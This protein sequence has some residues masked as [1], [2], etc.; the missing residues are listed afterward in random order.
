MPLTVDEVDAAATKLQSAHKG[1]STRTGGALLEAAIKKDD[2]GAVTKLLKDGSKP[3]PQ[4]LKL[5]LTG[6]DDRAIAASIVPLSSSWGVDAKKL[7]IWEAVQ[8]AL[9]PPAGGEDDEAAEAADV[10]SEEWQVALAQKLYGEEAKAGSPG[11]YEVKKV[12]A[13]GVYEGERAAPPDDPTY[14]PSFDDEKTQR[15]GYGVL[16]LPKGDV[17]VGHFDG[18]K[19]AGVGAYVHKSGGGVYVGEWKADKKHGEGRMAFKD[20]AV[21]DGSWRHHKRHG[22]GVYRYVNGDSYVGQ[23]FTGAKRAPPPPPRHRARRSHASPPARAITADG[24]GKYFEAKTG[25]RT[26]GTWANGALAAGSVR[27][28]AEVQNFHGGFAGGM[29][30][31]GGVFHFPRSGAIVAGS[32]PPPPPPAEEGEEAEAPPPPPWSGAT[33]GDETSYNIEEMKRQYAAAGPEAR[34]KRKALVVAVEYAPS[35]EGEAAP[36]AVFPPLDLAPVGAQLKSTLEGA[37]AFDDVTVLAPPHTKEAVVAAIDALA[38]SVGRGDVAVVA[39]VG[40]G[41]R[42]LDL[43]DDEKEEKGDGFC[44]AD[45][46]FTS[47]DLQES[48]AKFGDA[49]LCVLLD[50]CWEPACLAAPPA[51]AEFPSHHFACVTAALD[52]DAPPPDVP[53]PPPPAPPEPAE[54]EAPA[55]GETP[56]DGEAPAEGGE[57]PAEAEA[58][59]AAEGEAAPAEGEAAPP[60]EEVEAPP[61]TPGRRYTSYFSH[62]L[63]EFLAAAAPTVALGGAADNPASYASLVDAIV[64]AQAATDKREIL[65]QKFV[66]Y[67]RDGTAAALRP[68]A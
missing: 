28:A 53:A 61:P 3:T 43:D 17:Y 39:L 23:W 40:H 16:L 50:S 44:C 63:S 10:T 6:C 56:A 21:Y 59:P 35:A 34:P 57:A 65:K 29:P 46:V 8:E 48:A 68:L 2:L 55:E 58:A 30:T 22:R 64:R 62:S 20:G 52:A 19:K 26:A 32:Y 11:F 49:H 9:A 31:G 25:T 33:I 13:L 60:A 45:E 24:D 12:V 36:A 5:A 38:G 15:H 7:A 51:N 37:A 1:K 4:T 54:G 47:D 66:L 14:E 42:L 18:G 67:A 27:A 41:Q